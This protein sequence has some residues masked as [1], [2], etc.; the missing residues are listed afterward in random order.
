MYNIEIL[1]RKKAMKITKKK[2]QISYKELNQERKLI[3]LFLFSK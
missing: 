2:F 3:I 1:L